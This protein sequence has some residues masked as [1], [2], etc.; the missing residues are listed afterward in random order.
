MP[1]N[2]KMEDWEEREGSKG[3][4]QKEKAQ[5]ELAKA[6]AVIPKFQHAGSGAVTRGEVV[7]VARKATAPR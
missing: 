1:V 4:Q 2:R 3:K 6:R 7:G 5:A